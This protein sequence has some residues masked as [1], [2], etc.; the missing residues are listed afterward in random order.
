[1]I[2]QLKKPYEISIWEDRP[3]WAISTGEDILILDK[4]QYDPEI[5]KNNIKKQFLKERKLCVIGAHD[6]EAQ[7]RCVN[8]VLT[9]NVNAAATLTF[10]MYYNYKNWKTGE[11]EE[12]PYFGFITNERKVKLKYDEKWFDFII[13]N[14][15]ENSDQKSVNVTAKSAE[16]VEL[17]KTGYNI[18]FEESLGN[19]M[20]TSIE[21]AKQV[22]EGSDW[23]VR[24]T[25]N[26]EKDDLSDKLYQTED[27][28]VY[29]V[30]LKRNVIARKVYLEEKYHDNGSPYKSFKTD[31]TVL[32]ANSYIYIFY[33]ST[34]NKNDK[35]YQAC[36]ISGEPNL[37]ENRI[38]TN[39]INIYFSVEDLD[40]T[41]DENGFPDFVTYGTNFQVVTDFMCRRLVSS[42][43]GIYDPNLDRYVSKYYDE[44]KNPIYGYISTEYATT[45]LVENLIV[46]GEDFTSGDK[47]VSVDGWQIAQRNS[48]K[49]STAKIERLSIPRALVTK[50]QTTK[51]QDEGILKDGSGVM[52]KT[53]LHLQFNQHGDCVYNS[54]LFN[55][56]S[57]IG[58]LTKGERYI[59]DIAYDDVKNSATG[60]HDVFLA[61]F[62][63]SSAGFEIQKI[64]SS[65]AITDISSWNKTTV[66]LNG[67]QYYRSIFEIEINESVP[68]YKLVNGNVGIFIG[69]SSNDNDGISQIKAKQIRFF[70]KI[71]Y[72]DDKGVEKYIDPDSSQVIKGQILDFYSY[73][74]PN[75]NGGEYDKDTIKYL[76][77]EQVEGP[78]TPE[79]TWE[80]V[81]SITAKE[82][83]RFNIIQSIC[84]TFECWAD[85]IVN[86]TE[87]GEIITNF[88]YD[89]EDIK[90]EREKFIAL[91]EYLGKQN[92]V[93]FKYGIN[94]KSIQRNVDSE[95]IATKVIVKNNANTSAKNG[96]CS[97][98]RAK[99]NP[100]KENYVLNFDHYVN[101]K[102][103]DGAELDKDLYWT[104]DG[105]LGYFSQLKNINSK[106]EELVDKQT[107]Y[108][109]EL[110]K[111]QAEADTQKLLKDEAFDNFQEA[112][113][114]YEK[115][116][117]IRDL[118]GNITESIIWPNE[119]ISDTTPQNIKNA[120]DECAYYCAQLTSATNDYNSAIVAIEKYQK[121]F[122]GDPEAENEEERLGINRCL[123]KII[124]DKKALDKKFII[125]YGRFIQ[126][127]TWISEDYY[128]DELYY[129]DAVST[130]HTS[131]N[132]KI[133]YTIN[134]L[135]LSQLEGFEDFNFDLADITYIE[136]TEFFGYM[137]DGSGR[138]YHED[139]VV[140]EIKLALDSPE[141]N[142]L[143][144]QNYKTQF[145]DLFQRIAASTQTVEF[146][147]GQYARAASAFTTDGSIAEDSISNT[148]LNGN[149][150]IGNGA[151]HSVTYGPSGLMIR[152]VGGSIA[153]MLTRITSN[154]I[155]FYTDGGMTP[156]LVLGPYGFRGM[157]KVQSKL[158]IGDQI[159][160]QNGTLL[161]GKEDGINS[162][163]T[164][165]GLD[166]RVGTTSHLSLDGSGI[167]PSIRIG[168]KNGV[169]SNF[170]SNTLEFNNVDS[171]LLLINA[172]DPITDRNTT[173]PFIR[174]GKEGDSHFF[175]NSY[176]IHLG[177]GTLDNCIKYFEVNLTKEDEPN[178]FIRQSSQNYV[179]I[180]GNSFDIY[181]GSSS[182][183][184]I[185]NNI[186][187]L[188]G[189]DNNNS[190][191]FNCSG[192][193]QEVNSN[194]SKDTIIPAE[195]NTIQTN[196]N[197]ILR[198]TKQ[199]ASIRLIS[200][201]GIELSSY[202]EIST[203]NK[204]LMYITNQVF[205][206]GGKQ[207]AVIIRCYNGEGVYGT[208]VFAPSG[209]FYAPSSMGKYFRLF[210]YDNTNA[211]LTMSTTGVGKTGTAG[212]I[213][214]TDS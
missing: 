191:V 21:L 24:G 123:S 132:P 159:T 17:S 124:E 30:A 156:E 152:G 55:N 205:A 53:G 49:T 170:T 194:D 45:D 96:F 148:L 137:Q 177:K 12:N 64:I 46:N 105:Y 91:R 7:G 95:Q 128:D 176:G 169:H 52:G 147:G 31:T 151:T 78:Y 161:L 3:T 146:K 130:T 22:L 25:P 187:T 29:K 162:Y 66:D 41:L 203:W 133:S 149:L 199:E 165:T 164:S 139:V 75:Q 200:N 86:H 181:S 48:S 174:I 35:F 171:N 103:L 182:F 32:G 126:E 97:I 160:L 108:S 39:A 120:Y 83:N 14:I 113:K 141:T 158:V 71:V 153:N 50:A 77:R 117:S 11:T 87:T 47:D 43:R 155:S 80:K 62:A 69:V 168:L 10:T 209:I 98:A 65:K 112:C 109:N 183:F 143:K 118:E 134:V 34:Q 90:I 61:Y 144:I 38:A 175:V 36:Y 19:N 163:L 167:N 94:L 173:P 193:N 107:Q 116:A 178:V 27:E 44:N 79:Y 60:T 140:A 67:C 18:D 111:W 51:E 8:P 88:S 196:T 20:D 180:T 157:L 212:Q 122:E 125:K 145:D 72:K 129:F 33:S 208:Y 119:I 4:E 81:R 42:H 198:G 58:P 138:P 179:K 136:D 202:R 82:S 211:A 197:L 172:G 188:K 15:Q 84:E 106:N 127:G 2:E 121:K 135:E 73:Y 115:V 85:F 89:G 40:F 99:A 190:L 100:I 9:R 185:A 37:D 28:T 101:K 195:S 201:G 150:I 5:Y 131:A 68:L 93:G 56:A 63:K 214:I 110:L 192:A 13:K 70:K 59:F 154:G 76:Y 166:F 1:M 204:S 206:G 114:Y 213:A 92:F 186:L 104:T 23:E 184:K 74:D 207:G 6:M 142:T 189:S 102:L 54:G 26:E 210:G 57:K 16:V